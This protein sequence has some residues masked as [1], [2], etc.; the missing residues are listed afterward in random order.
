MRSDCEAIPKGFTKK[1]ADKA[2]TMEAALPT[3]SGETGAG[4]RAASDAAPGC[5]VYWPAPYEVCGA[6]RDKYNELG[7]PNGFLLFP[8]S[9]ELTNPDGHGK[10]SVFQ[11]GPIHWSA[12]SGAHPVV[13]HFFAAWQR[14]GWESGPLGYPT[15]DEMVNPDNI[16]RRQYFQGGTIYWRLNEAY[17]VTGAIRDKWGETGWEGGW[18]GYP[19]SDE[20]KLPD[21]QGR[22][23]RFEHG[24][25][26]W[27]PAT[28]AHPVTAAVLDQ[29]SRAG[30]ETSAYGYPTADPVT[31]PG[32]VQEQQ[33][34]HH[35][36]YSS[37]LTIPVAQ[38]VSLSLGVPSTGPLQP[39]AVSQGVALNG[40]GF[41]ARFQRVADD[42]SFEVSL[43]RLDA[44]A[45]ASL[46]LLF[47]A[48]AGYRLRAT[49][50]RV[51]LVDA[52]GVIV[53]GVG[54][55]MGFDATGAAVPVRATFEGNRLRLQLGSSTALPIEFPAIAT[56]GGAVDKWWSSGTEQRKVC[57]L[58][59]HDC[60]RVRNANGPAQDLAKKAFPD[61]T[62]TEDNRVDAARH[63]IWNGLMT[64]GSNRGF[65]ERMAAAHETDGK[66]SPGWHRNGALMDEYNNKTGVQVGLR[67]EG[68]P[69]TIQSTCL[70]YGQEARIVPE[71]DTIDLTNPSGIDLI[72]LRH[73]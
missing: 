70:R 9:N 32:G 46:D 60:V 62:D 20:I 21:G 2:E 5:Q 13:N 37:G 57:A 17:Y 3:G 50:Q 6:I 47:G 41:K 43:V 12:S 23:N 1:Q 16:G 63:C 27:S 51:E 25:V 61:T 64:E 14:N 65:A 72:A 4:P 69:G 66:S 33:F 35:R 54:L 31:H 19:T 48:P 53:A 49:P 58:E 29:W 45:P 11:N 55:P 68:S 59:P 73:P 40:P 28:G 34:Q 22:M 39:E 15:S 67:N 26:Y 36:I 52:A 56:K 8:T 71:P 24:V 44:S 42:G 10:R 30:Y 18:L 7:G 38:G